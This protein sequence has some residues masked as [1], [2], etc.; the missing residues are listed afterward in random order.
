MSSG[1][2]SLLHKWAGS[3]RIDAEEFYRLLKGV[4]EEPVAPWNLIGS[5]DPS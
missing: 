2:I 1:P 4:V 3:H 5:Q